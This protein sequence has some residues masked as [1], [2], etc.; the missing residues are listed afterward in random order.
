LEALTEALLLAW[1]GLETLSEALLN[2]KAEMNL[3]HRLPFS[4]K[5]WTLSSLIDM[6]DIIVL[7]LLI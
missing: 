3:L 5:Q 1:A 2:T 6:L 7:A 4:Q